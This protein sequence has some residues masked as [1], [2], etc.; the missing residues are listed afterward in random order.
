MKTLNLST[1]ESFATT[2]L[3]K[4]MGM[5]E[6]LKANNRAEVEKNKEKKGGKNLREEKNRKNGRRRR[7]IYFQKLVNINL[8]QTI[9]SQT[10]QTS[11]QLPENIG[12]F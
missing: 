11:L 9:N 7:K 6:K 3:G 1:G 5:F 2:D 10:F 8:V 4:G 12:Q